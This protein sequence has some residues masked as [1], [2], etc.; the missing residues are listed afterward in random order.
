MNHHK[1]KR[2]ENWWNNFAKYPN[3]SLDGATIYQIRCFVMH[4]TKMVTRSKNIDILALSI[5]N[6]FNGIGI[7]TDGQ[8][9]NKHYYRLDLYGFCTQVCNSFDDYYE[10]HKDIV[11]LAD[12]ELFVVTDDELE[13]WKQGQITITDLCTDIEK[14]HNADMLTKSLGEV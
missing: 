13:Q 9:D 4:E 14:L 10:T 11:D 12:I 7:N 5:S 2:Y 1:K 8:L 6:N 3:D